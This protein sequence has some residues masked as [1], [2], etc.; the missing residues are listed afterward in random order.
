MSSKRRTPKRLCLCLA[1][2]GILPLAQVSLADEPAVGAV[3][4]AGTLPTTTVKATRTNEANTSYDTPLANTATKIPVPLRDIPQSVNV[5]P[6]A[7]IQDQSALSLNDALRNVPGV[8]ASLGDAQRDQVTIRG[9]SSINDQYVDGLRDDSLYY[10]DLSNID[11]IEVLKGPA[12]VLYGRGS[13]GGI[14]NRVTKK[15]Q[16]TTFAEVGTLFGTEGQKRGEIDLNTSIHDD[17]VRA[18][19]TG[20]IEDSSGFRDG[21]FLR[22]QAIAPSF[23][24][25]FSTDTKLTLQFDYLHDKR[26]ADQGVPSYHGRPVDVPIETR[27]GSANAAD[28][29]VEST[30]KSATGIFDHRFNDRWSFHSAVRTYEYTLGRNNYTT[31]KSVTD[32]PVPTVTLNVNQRNRNDR[33]TL[34]QNEVTQKAETFG[35]QHTLLYGIELGYQDK[36]DRVSGLAKNTVY[37]LFD[38]TLVV[39]PTVPASAT[40]TNYG[41]THNETYAAYAQDL[42]R[43]SPQWTLLAGFR[44]EALRQSRDDLT[45]KNQDIAR[46]DKPF[47]P[48]VGIIYHPVEPL[49]LYASYSRSFQ[50][51]AD[52]FTYYA[53]SS[54]LAPQ[55]TTNYEIGAKYDLPIGASITAA[56]FDMKQTNL[57][58]VDPAT[59]L[60]VPIGTQRTRGL[61]LSMAGEVAPHWQVMA[62]YAYLDGQLENPLDKSGGGVNDNQPALTPRHSGSLWIKRDLPNGFYVAGGVRA[63]GARYASQYNVTTLP[64]YMTVDLGA[65]YR[66]KHLDVTLTVQN[67]L[68]RT[69]YVSAHGGAENYNMP[70]APLTALVGVRYKI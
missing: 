14:I 4:D 23:Q 11:R 15:P 53:N 61:E 46:T 60:A 30:I 68:D 3:R 48:R 12:A 62:S 7:V 17:A 32:G 70:G 6:H 36:T 2:L 42:I 13:A 57:T 35:I 55:E 20:A 47:S 64:G 43:F 67:L 10:R 34:W 27:Y 66:S 29:N 5:V 69:Y 39:L 54:A 25:N 41:R 59:L 24:F 45:P 8:S 26:I 31:V 18:R 51:I 9:F 16:A 38:P 21:Y 28:G 63:E 1:S 40:P 56:L 49:S 22:R 50:P 33:G 65:G 37:N 44:Y 19:L 52:S 58:G